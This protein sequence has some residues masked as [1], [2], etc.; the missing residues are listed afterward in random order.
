MP[1]QELLAKMFRLKYLS[2]IPPPATGFIHANR[3]PQG[4]F[5]ATKRVKKKL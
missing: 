2:T 4:V 3:H 1:A 5:P